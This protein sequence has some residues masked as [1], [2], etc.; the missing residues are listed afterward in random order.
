M[1][2]EIEP[3]DPSGDSGVSVL[4]GDTRLSLKQFQDMYAE[5]GRSSDR[6]HKGIRAPFVLEYDDLK[7]LNQRL[8]HFISHLHVVSSKLKID[9]NHLGDDVRE[10]DSFEKFMTYDRATISPIKSILYE[11]TFALPSA[12]GLENRIRE[13]TVGI[14]FSSNVAEL[15]ENSEDPNTEDVKNEFGFVEMT[16]FCNV[17][18]YDY[19][20]A[21]SCMS[22]ITDWFKGLQVFSDSSIQK[23]LFR[24]R[25]NAM[26][27][28]HTLMIIPL[29][30]SFA[31]VWNSFFAENLQN[32][33]VAG[34]IIA[35]LASS[36]HRIF[37]HLSLRL[38]SEIIKTCAHSIIAFNA[39]DKR[40][41]EWYENK[42]ERF[43]LVYMSKFIGAVLWAVSIGV[44]VRL[45]LK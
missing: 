12:L 10:F 27:A 16:A 5:L 23:F 6:L 33:V 41:R 13:Y 43:I 9:I 17:K 34:A 14:L 45:I 19:A 35:G 8:Q 7:N 28:F 15:K 18:Y 29:M 3:L 1:N 44:I 25:K 21:V 22:I 4:L 39:G 42:R 31:L 11:L 24:H 40:L 30:V 26:Y 37:H 32:A 2:G 36:L 20:V 38:N